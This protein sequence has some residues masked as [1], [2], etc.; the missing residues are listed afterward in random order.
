MSKRRSH[1]CCI[2]HH[3][4]VLIFMPTGSTEWYTRK[5]TQSASLAA[6]IRSCAW[7]GRSL[8][9]QATTVMLVA[10]NP[11]T[12]PSSPRQLFYSFVT[13]CGV[14]RHDSVVHPTAAASGVAPSTARN[15]LMAFMLPPYQRRDVFLFI[16]AMS[17]A[18]SCFA[19]YISSWS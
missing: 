16:T 17:S 2:R 7:C 3:S 19:L 15:A 14:S 6:Q 9:P 12:R 8:I 11:T 13:M 1:R 10:V 18:F 4:S 5:L